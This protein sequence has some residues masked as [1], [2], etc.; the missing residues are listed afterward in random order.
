MY[1]NG[2]S[3]LDQDW[4]SIGEYMVF[5]GGRALKFLAV[6]WLL[7]L[8]SSIFWK[9]GPLVFGHIQCTFGCG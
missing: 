4:E 9:A 3:T 5:L 7:L 1:E 6:A 8:A 2:S